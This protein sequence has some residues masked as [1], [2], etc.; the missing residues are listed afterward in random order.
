MNRATEPRI[1]SNRVNASSNALSPTH[2]RLLLD[3]IKQRVGTEYFQK[4]RYLWH[5][6][7]TQKKA[8][9]DLAVLIERIDLGSGNKQV[10]LLPW[11]D[12]RIAGAPVFENIHAAR[13]RIDLIPLDDWG[14]VESQPINWFEVEGRRV[15]TPV[16]ASTGTPL[17]SYLMYLIGWLE[18]YNVNPPASGYIN[19]LAVPTDYTT[20]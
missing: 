2:P 11:T 15:F 7:P 18:F 14:R 20:L 19:A 5:L 17:A 9:E 3:K 12:F 4:G 16:G 13:D 10:D 1:R 8:W 6:H